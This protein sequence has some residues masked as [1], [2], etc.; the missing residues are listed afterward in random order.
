LLDVKFICTHFEHTLLDISNQSF[1]CK[2][3]HSC[4]ACDLSN[5]PR[6]L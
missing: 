1:E 6:G 2:A 5:Q 4:A 3:R